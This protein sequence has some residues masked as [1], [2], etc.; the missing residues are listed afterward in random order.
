VFTIKRS[1]RIERTLMKKILKLEISDKVFAII[2]TAVFVAMLIPLFWL[3]KYTTPHYDDYDMGLY[4]KTFLMQD[5][6]FE[7]SNLIDGLHYRVKT[8]YYAWQGTYASALL[9]ALVPINHYYIGTSIILLLFI[10]SMYFFLKI[11]AKEVL[12]ISTSKIIALQAFVTGSVLLLIHTA[13]EG[14]YWYNGGVHYTVITSLAL[15]YLGCLI[16]IIKKKGKVATVANVFLS[17]ILA[18]FVAGGNFVTLLLTLVI[19]LTILFLEILLK[20]KRAILMI[21]SLVIYAIGFYFNVSAPGNAV[22]AAYFVSVKKG[23]V[24]AVLLSFK[25]AIDYIRDFRGM[26]FFFV[27]CIGM[28]P[29]F[30]KVVC[31]SKVVFR[32][33]L[34]VSIWSFCIYAAGFTP[35]YYGMGNPGPGRSLNVVKIVL[36][37]MIVLNEVYWLGWIKQLCEKKNWKLDFVKNY[38]LLNI[39]VLGVLGLIFVRNCEKEATFSAYAAIKTLDNDYAKTYY[40][41]YME[42]IELLNSDEMDVVFEPY[43][44]RPWILSI[45][46]LSDNPDNQM[47]VFMARYYFK[48]SV[49]VNL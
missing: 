32:F 6:H 36:M 17:M 13:Q 43:N 11:L 34:L 40:A 27:L 35:C 15:L 38:L 19:A 3:C 5:D 24:E 28:I 20:E 30:Y 1:L 37:L 48:N 4:T 41:Q 9:M 45:S 2:L 39:L 46:E 49:R 12:G 33:P 47:N 23:A 10:A 25:S 29:F 31:E 8:T 44:P 42:R 16:C 21:P 14:I 26:M 22:R 18:G 7:L